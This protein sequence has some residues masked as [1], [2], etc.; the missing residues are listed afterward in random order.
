MLNNMKKMNFKYFYIIIA[1]FFSSIT[2]AQSYEV[3]DGDTINLVDENGL[4]QGF[5]RIF[6]RM[7]KLPEY[8][9]DQV[10]EEGTYKDS[11]KNGLWKR[12]FPNGKVKDE[13]EYVNNRPNGYYR[14]YYENGQI[15]EEGIWQRNRNVGQFKRYYEN[16]QVAQEFNFNETGKRD[17][18]QVYYYENGQI[19]IEGEWAAGKESGEIVEYYENGDIKAKKIFNDGVM[20]TTKSQIFEPKNPIKEKDEEDLAESPEK[21]V[22]VEADEKPNVGKFDGNGPFKLYN[23]N[24]QLVKDGVFKNYRLMDG[25]WYKYTD[26]GILYNIEVYKK[27]KYIGDAPLPE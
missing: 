18:K 9:P 16:G 2:V 7:K 5:W 4:K 3:I 22:K 26:D 13:I 20:D 14:T 1:L 24:K 19:M 11:K 25:K 21:V 10:V 12:F 17:G 6:G 23:K 27:G 15:Q 8:Q